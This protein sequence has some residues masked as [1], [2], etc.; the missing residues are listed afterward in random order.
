MAETPETK[1]GDASATPPRY[2]TLAD[3]ARVAGVHATTVSLALRDHPSIPAETRARIR[4]VAKELGYRRDP[5]LDAFN[6]HRVKNARRP[7]RL[8][9][10][11]V[12]DG[13]ATRFFGPKAYH[14]LVFDGARAVA[15]AHNYSIDAFTIGPKDLA[16]SRLKTILSTR[17][18]TGVLLSTF[19]IDT[20]RLELDWEHYCT[21]KI[22][23]LHLAPHCDAVSSDQLQ[24]ARLAMRRLRE[25]GYRRIGL[26]TA[27]EDE[28]RLSESFRMGVLVEQTALPEDERVAP[29]V[30][31]LADVPALP[32]ILPEWLRAERVDVII[33]NWNELLDTFPAAHVRIPEQVAFA[34]LDA[35][36]TMPHVAGVVQ[37]HRLVGIRAMEQLC[38]MA[39]THQ[40]GPVE[41]QSITY[42]P[43][44]W[45]DGATTPIRSRTWYP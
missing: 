15:E 20:S 33:S 3:V 17:G 28:S 12:V 37:N 11:F 13:T 21:V 19:D 40:R 4:G 25:C 41:T 10:A 27:R 18:I 16:P 1:P 8:A 45:R 36:P 2:L 35:P 44:F 29:L 9:M 7:R 6:F 43:G 26:A 38:L 39:E 14:P 24:V 23:S 32:S 34:S 31:A 42:V 5:L 30:F 22:E